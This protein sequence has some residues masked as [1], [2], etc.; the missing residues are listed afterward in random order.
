[1]DFSDAG[2]LSAMRRSSWLDR[3]TA[4]HPVKVISY[5]GAPSNNVGNNGDFCVDEMCNILYGPKTGGFWPEDG[6]R[7][8][9][10][11]VCKRTFIAIEA[12]RSTRRLSTSPPPSDRK[13]VSG[14][15]RKLRSFLRFLFALRSSEMISLD[16]DCDVSP[17]GSS[18]IHPLRFDEALLG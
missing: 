7:I 2:A 5:M 12:A 17:V 13:L 18:S 3:A 10:P 15:M 16:L 1:M 6:V 8:T 14:F 4:D 11:V 9:G